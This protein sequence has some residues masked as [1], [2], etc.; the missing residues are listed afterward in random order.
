[1]PIPTFRAPRSAQERA[2]A[3]GHAFRAPGAFRGAASNT[4]RTISANME[5]GLMMKTLLIVSAETTPIPHDEAQRQR[6]RADEAPR[7]LLLEERL[8]AD[9]MDRAYLQALSRPRRLLY[10]PFPPSLVQALEA[11]RL[12]RAYDVVVTWDDR[13]SL[14]YA[15]LV[16]LTPGRASHHVAMV[17]WMAPANKGMLLKLVH[18]SIN[19]IV[20]WGAMQKD[21][22]SELFAIPASKIVATSYFADQQFF[23][24]LSVPTDG[25]CAVGNSKRDYATLIEAMRG[26]PISCR[27]ITHAAPSDHQASDWGVTWRALHDTRALPDDI[28]I[29][30]ATPTELRH[31]YASS[32]FVVVPLFASLGD[33]GITALAE[34]MAMGKAVICSKIRG[35]PDFFEHGV[36]GLLVPPGDARALREAIQYL[37]AHPEEAERMGAEGRRRAEEL[38]SL[39]GFVAKIE[40]IVR[41]VSGSSE[42]S[43]TSASGAA[44]VAG[45]GPARAA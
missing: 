38:F 6:E 9:V 2:D 42:A 10:R 32:R 29:H 45:G 19:R 33:F 21:L 35:V 27:I 36:T 11:Y 23:R 16:R 1:M 30:S 13:V 26:L 20:V 15:A 22:L 3:K 17:T 41:E 12:H 43:G 34:S 25:I 14:M 40:R 4:H 31:C 37:S 18:K 39:D 8:H 44:Q 28:L 5:K 7:T 24:P